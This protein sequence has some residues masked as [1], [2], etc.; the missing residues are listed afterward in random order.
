MA[1]WDPILLADHND[2]LTC[3]PNAGHLPCFNVGSKARRSC[4]FPLSAQLHSKNQEVTWGEPHHYPAPA[5]PSWCTLC[6]RTWPDSTANSTDMLGILLWLLNYM[7]WSQTAPSWSAICIGDGGWEWSG[8]LLLREADP[9]TLRTFR[10][11]QECAYSAQQAGTCPVLSRGYTKV[12]KLSYNWSTAGDHLKKR[13]K[14]T[15]KVRK[16]IS[17]WIWIFFLIIKEIIS[18][19]PSLYSHLASWEFIHGS[20]HN[21]WCLAKCLHTLDVQQ[22]FA[23][24]VEWCSKRYWWSW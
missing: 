17:R 22:E 9:T 5:L 14:A 16:C 11:Q 4:P 7:S 2:F 13:L 8:W 3:S 1:L 23:G 24:C 21:L 10:T 6:P 19:L 12:Q 18:C 15:L 20:T